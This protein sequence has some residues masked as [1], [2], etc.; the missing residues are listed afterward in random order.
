[1]KYLLFIIGALALFGA[2][3]YTDPAAMHDGIICMS[4][5]GIIA[6]I[7]RLRRSRE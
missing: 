7:D 5:Y 2:V 4:A 6:A 1:V 3:R